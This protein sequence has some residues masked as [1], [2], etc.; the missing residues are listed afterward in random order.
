MIPKIIHQTWKTDQVPS[1]WTAFAESWKQHHPDWQ[2]RLWTN[3]D[4]AEFVEQFYPQF[5]DTY[6][7]YQYDIQRADAIRYL[8]IYHYGGVYADL[9]FECLQS[10]ES[11]CNNHKLLIGFEP[12][13]HAQFQPRQEV[14]CNAIFGSQPHSQFLK[15]VIEFLI[16]DVTPTLVHEDVLKTTGP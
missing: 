6:W 1:E 16:A 3:A 5:K 2:Y 12:K 11:L 10:F 7:S 15:T 9:D 4:G 14:L 8:I 13:G